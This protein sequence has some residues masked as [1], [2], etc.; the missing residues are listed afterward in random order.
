VVSL[1]HIGRFN[2]CNFSEGDSAEDQAEYFC[3]KTTVTIFFISTRLLVLNFL[4]KGTKFNQDYFI[5]MVLPNLY[6]EKRR[7][8]RRKGP[9]SFSVHI[10][11]SMCHN[12]A[13]ITEKLEKK[14]I[15][16]APHPPYSPDLSPC[17]FWLF[18]I[19]KQKMKERVSQSE[20]QILVAITESGNELTFEDI[21]RVSI[22]GWN[23]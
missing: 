5:D 12:G 14:H 19:T 6:S 1:Y 16:P 17:D 11:N 4:P 7:I 2:V 10:D 13:K 18:E 15:A 22:I 3:Q 20:E 9:P 23:A 8:A 21:Q